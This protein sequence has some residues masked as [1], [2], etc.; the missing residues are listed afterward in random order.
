MAYVLKML[1]TRKFL[2]QNV[3]LVLPTVVFPP[4]NIFKGGRL[5]ALESSLKSHRFV[6]SDERTVQCQ[7]TGCGKMFK[8]KAALV[9]HMRS[10]S[11]DRPFPCPLADCDSEFK[12]NQDLLRHAR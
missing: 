8:H 11:D 9:V 1:R 5:F 6:H 7:E 12:T 4:M 3:N 2:V 10:H